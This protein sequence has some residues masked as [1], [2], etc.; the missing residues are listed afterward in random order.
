MP[1]ENVNTQ[2]TWE[3]PQEN[4]GAGTEETWTETEDSWSTGVCTL[5]RK[6]CSFSNL[7]CDKPYR[8]GLL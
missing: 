6:N 5:C 1:E 4:W 2:D 7:R 8:E 3:E